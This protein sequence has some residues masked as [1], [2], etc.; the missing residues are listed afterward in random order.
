VISLL[1]NI[2]SLRDYLAKLET[3]A[4]IVLDIDNTV[5]KAPDY[6]GSETWYDERIELLKKEGW[7]EARAT[8]QANDE[9]EQIQEKISP[10]PVELETIPLLNEIQS[11]CSLRV[12]GLTTRRSEIA[13]LTHQ[14]LSH[15]GFTFDKNCPSPSPIRIDAHSKYIGGVLYIGPLHEKGTALKHML[16]VISWRPKQILFV[17]DRLSQLSSMLE[18]VGV[19]IPTV[20]LQYKPLTPT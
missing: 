15:V 11:N 9:W 7:E 17:D 6:W 10:I 2:S 20:A 19:T 14:Q 16:S 1:E 5:L 3:P 12:M 18:E 8:L 13:E 4:L